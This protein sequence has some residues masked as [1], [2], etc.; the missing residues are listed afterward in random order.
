MTDLN[1]LLP[2][3]SQSDPSLA[4]SQLLRAAM[5]RVNFIPGVRQ[6]LGWRG[7][8]ACPQ[9]PMAQTAKIAQRD[10]VYGIKP[11]TQ[12]DLDGMGLATFS[13]FYFPQATDAL[14][15]SMSLAAGMTAYSPHYDDLIREFPT[16]QD[17]AGLFQIADI[18]L[19]YHP[20]RQV[21]LSLVAPEW[22]RIIA[23]DGVLTDVDGERQMLVEPG[24]PEQDLP[25]LMLAFDFFETL[26]TSLSYIFEAAPKAMQQQSRTHPDR[27]VRADGSHRLVEKDNTGNGLKALR[28]TWGLDPIAAIVPEGNIDTRDWRNEE[29]VDS[30]PSAR[31]WDPMVPGALHSMDKSTMGIEELPKLIVLTGFLGS[32]K[33][34]FLSHFIDYQASRNLF[35]AVIQNEIGEKGLDARLLGQHYAVKEIDE[36]CICCTLIDN[37]T[38]AINEICCQYQPDFIIL[39]TTGL[40]NPANLLSELSELQDRMEF[41]S[42]TCMLDALN[43]GKALPSYAHSPGPDPGGRYGADQQDGSG[44]AGHGCSFARGGA[45]AQ[46]LLRH[47]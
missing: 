46:S 33:T 25:S 41:C 10:G 30:Y 20:S 15:N 23:D 28:L 7:M 38:V 32:G 47:V 19:R 45:R 12:A 13:L 31:W 3:D 36:G 26:A 40:A 9:S 5:M 34:S 8:R 21:T 2:P 37:L 27:H 14:I 42:V 4:A 11:E 6:R 18:E 44:R 35:V 29:E 16:H 43:A 39:E 22:D 24:Q 1:K 17:M